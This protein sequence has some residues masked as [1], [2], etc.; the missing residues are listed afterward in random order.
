M[1]RL[2]STRGRVV[3]F[4]VATLLTLVS[5][6]LGFSAG[7]SPGSSRRIGG[8]SVHGFS[9][10]HSVSTCRRIP[11]LTMAAAADDSFDDESMEGSVVK[12]KVDPIVKETALLLRRLSWLTWW[13]QLILTTVSSVTLLF[14]RNVIGASTASSY[15]IATSSLP[16]FLLAGLGIGLSFG[17]IFW[18]WASRRLARRLLRKPTKPLEAAAMLRKSIN[19]GVTLNLFGMLTSLISA[20]QI[21]GALAI[22][23]LTSAPAR[24]T[25]ALLESSSSYL[26]PLDILVVQANTNTLFSHFSCLAALLYMTKSLVKLDPPSS[27][28][29]K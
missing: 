1:T 19:V 13:S 29:N 17:S 14:A 27:K 12:V 18:T 7:T 8:N 2:I 20:E 26:Q 21:V 15:A 24:T 3:L 6:S 4:W 25:V 10:C 9:L 5:T 11:L 23:V 28:V 22:K 16:N